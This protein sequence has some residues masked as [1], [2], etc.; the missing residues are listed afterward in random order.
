MS[1]RLLTI[2]VLAAACLVVMLVARRASRRLQP[3]I[4]ARMNHDVRTPMNGVIGLT[5]ALL[6]TDLDETQRQY[7]R[8]I[9]S[10]GDSLLAAIQEVL[11]DVPEGDAGGLVVPAPPP[12]APAPCPGPARVLVAEDNH[13]NQVVVVAML[14]KLGYVV[15]VAQNGREAVEM[16]SHDQFAA[17]LMDCQMPQ[18]DGYDATREIRRRERDGPRTPIIAVTAHAMTSDRDECL[19]AGMD[20]YICKP[21]RAGELEAALGRWVG[22][23][24]NA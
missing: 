16:C 13:I 21:L 7:V 12:P 4:L 5:E 18:L 10:C 2:A 9:R 17:V 6:D 1:V 15:A 22:A 19:D 14:K 23:G 20:D 24:K 11:E 8:M 3:E